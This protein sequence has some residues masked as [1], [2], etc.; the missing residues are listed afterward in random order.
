MAIRRVGPDPLNVVRMAEVCSLDAAHGLSTTTR[1]APPA[2]DDTRP[3]A[4]GPG[5]V[6][7]RCDAYEAT[8]P[9]IAALSR[10]SEQ[11]S[12]AG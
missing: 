8:T 7:D 11:S 1:I 6:A 4:G 9:T 5:V 3:P 12:G 2:R 10:K